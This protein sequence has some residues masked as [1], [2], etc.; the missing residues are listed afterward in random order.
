[1]YDELQFTASIIYM[2]EQIYHKMLSKYVYKFTIKLY[3]KICYC[4]IP[5]VLYKKI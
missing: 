4:Y 1:M 3:H 2:E 5:N